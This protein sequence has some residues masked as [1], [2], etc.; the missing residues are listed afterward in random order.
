MRHPQPGRPPANRA[1]PAARPLAVACALMLALTPPAAAEEAPLAP[2]SCLI[3]PDELVRL[4]TPV[5]GIVAEV[6]VDRGDPVAEGDVIARLDTTLEQITL[7]LAQARA[8]DQTR[9]R[10]LAARLDFLEAQAER[11]RD[12]AARNAISQIAALEAELDADIA[13]HALDEARIAHEIA[14]IELAQAEALLEQK[15]LRAPIDGIVVERLLT[16]GE[17][18]DTQSHIATIARIDKLRVEA[19]A[20]LAYRDRLATGQRVTIHPEEPV[21]GAYPATI[22]VIDRV[23]DAATA[24]FGLRME[25]PNPDLTLPA[26]LRCEVVFGG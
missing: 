6:S 15:V 9:I 10:S 2:I 22:T 5:A 12:L 4:A 3:E 1:A 20:P 11:T 25:L 13:R 16:R 26:G 8:A 19:F 23:F 18:P 17:F 14:A 21:G 24:T 7:S